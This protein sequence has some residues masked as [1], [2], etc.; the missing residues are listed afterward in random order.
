MVWH[1]SLQKDGEELCRSYLTRSL[2]IPEAVITAEEEIPTLGA[3]LRGSE[4]HPEVQNPSG[5]TDLL[6]RLFAL[7][8]G[9]P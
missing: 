8:L 9:T 1:T 2:A 6:G 3:E 7:I 5:Q 4:L